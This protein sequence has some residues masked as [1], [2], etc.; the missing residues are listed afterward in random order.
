MIH[1]GRDVQLVTRAEWAARTPRSRTSLN[2]T[3]GT[4]IH[5]EGPHIGDHDHAGCF[6]LVRGIQAYHMDTK[7]WS[8]VAYTALACPHGYAFEG[9]WLRTRTAAN[10][11][12]T[13]NNRAYAVCY[14]GGQ[15][16]PLT[17]HGKRAIRALVEFLHTRGDAGPAVN[18]HR[19][20]KATECPGNELY[21]WVRAGLPVSAPA[22]SP[23]PATPRGDKMLH[24]IKTES[25]DEW[26]LTD[27]IHKRHVQSREDAQ[28]VIFAAASAG[29]P[30]DHADNN[31][32]H[33][34]DDS[35]QDVIDRIPTA[36]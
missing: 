20:W 8:D 7:G 35:M 36:Q 6:T 10:G 33:V 25:R 27:F 34:W 30:I 3:Y 16:D 1:L 24:L 15:G 9:R 22:P 32:P 29:H 12:N 23:P 14:L 31:Q 5:W 18:A 21:A 4:T 11:T 26:W 19:D 28:V 2:P 13:G 17:V